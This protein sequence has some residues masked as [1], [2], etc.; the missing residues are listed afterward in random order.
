MTNGRAFI[1]VSGNTQDEESQLGDCQRAADREG[2]TLTGEPFRLHAVS[3]FKANKK[4]RDALD[5]ALAVI[6]SGE[7]TA[8]VVAHSSRL[9]R[10][11]PDDVL[12][13]G[14]QV[15][16]AG[17]RV[18][19][20]DE[21]NFGND[22]LAGRLVSMLA[23]DENNKHSK[24]LSGHVNRKFRNTID[25]SG[26]FRGSVPDGYMVTGEKYAKKL[27]P[28]VA[29]VR[30]HTSAEIA[31]VIRD[32][33]TGTSTTE[34]GRR[35]GTNADVIS[36]MLRNMVYSTG[37]YEVHRADGVTV[38]H[39]C[40]PLVEPHEQAAALAGLA[41]R[42]TG[43]NVSSRRIV[44]R[45]LSGAVYCVCGHRVGMHRGYS[46]SGRIR[47]D[48]TASPTARRYVCKACGRSVDADYAD[49]AVNELMSARTAFPWMTRQ[50]IPGDSNAADLD[51]V[52]LEY[53]ELSSRGLDFD[54][55]DQERERLRAEIRRLESLPSTPA[56]VITG[57]RYDHDGHELTEA[58]RW[59]SL[60][61]AGRRELL[62][63]GEFRVVLRPAHSAGRRPTGAVAAELEYPG[64]PAEDTRY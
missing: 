17:G 20:H 40:E 52:K 30:K 36:K 38:T 35:L 33:G 32:A 61:N 5:D 51:R 34:L 64:E 4:H 57:V 28:D 48:G 18:I 25:A 16:R 11:E 62:T 2:V 44:K 56:R 23:A 31:Q 21:P 22:D 29:G 8:I 63:N 9:T 3:G 42:L 50:V 37:R 19:S 53:R 49:S 26:S 15:R 59:L 45:D 47:K 7:I 1:R 27:V 39:R 41:A 54:T 12:M 60:D 46:G 55:E 10:G 6:E 58:D 13:Y 43:D 14:I 24:D